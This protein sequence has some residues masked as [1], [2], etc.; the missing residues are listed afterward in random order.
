MEEDEGVEGLKQIWRIHSAPA[1]HTKNTQQKEV[2]TIKETNER[3]SKKLFWKLHE[4]LMHPRDM[5]GE[6]LRKDFSLHKG[7]R[8]SPASKQASEGSSL[9]FI[10]HNNIIRKL[11]RS[12]NICRRLFDNPCEG[13]QRWKWARKMFYWKAS[14]V[15]WPD[16]DEGLFTSP[17]AMLKA[18][19]E[20]KIWHIFSPKYHAYIKSFRLVL[21]TSSYASMA[22]SSFITLAE[23]A[24]RGKIRF[25]NP[26]RLR[27]E[28]FNCLWK[29]RLVNSFHTFRRKT[30]TT[31]SF[32]SPSTLS[33]LTA[34]SARKTRSC[35]K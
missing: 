33:S 35:K 8:A 6:R 20:E 23:L 26:R 2:V 32:S 18:E 21:R 30:F 12:E 9:E 10:W 1:Q 28:T 24:R 25:L 14:D 16:R 22:R 31:K 5:F 7:T 27:H 3:K 19:A 15:A 29:S 11:E 13:W 17:F 4:N 34:P